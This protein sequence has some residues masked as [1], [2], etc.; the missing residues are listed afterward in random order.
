MYRYQLERMR[1]SRWIGSTLAQL[2]L[3]IMIMITTVFLLGF[4]ADPI[5]NLYLDPVETF[6]SDPLGGP[7]TLEV[8][9]DEDEMGGWVVHIM[10]GLASLGL[11]GAVKALFSFS[12]FFNFRLMLG[13]NRNGRAANRR[14]R[15]ENLN[16]GLLIIGIL[17]F[18][19]V[20]LVIS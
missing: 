12:P 5:L 9:L 19:W 20:S 10:K 11:L 13:G 7:S 4:V 3:T 2:A 18:L 6:T 14:E 17:T 1:W 15:L 16:W 8:I